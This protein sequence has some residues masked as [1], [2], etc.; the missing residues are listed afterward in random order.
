MSR[1]KNSETLRPGT[2][3]V[4][5]CKLRRQR[6][7]LK[8]SVRDVR[9]FIASFDG[10]VPAASTRYRWERIGPPTLKRAQGYSFL[11][12]MAAMHVYGGQQ[13]DIEDFT[14]RRV[15]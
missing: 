2:R 7:R 4:W 1:Y 12:G 3:Q 9:S 14:G 5:A 10:P 8:L 11:I 6:K 13:I 15:G